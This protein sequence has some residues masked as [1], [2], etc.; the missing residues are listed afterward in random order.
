MKSILFIVS[1]GGPLLMV[2]I[3]LSSAEVLYDFFKTT[4]EKNPILFRIFGFNEK[5]MQDKKAWVTHFKVYI[6]LIAAL[7][8][9]IGLSMALGV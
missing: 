9:V 4:R 6:I 5:Y 2:I 1:I 8:G 3:V 7:I